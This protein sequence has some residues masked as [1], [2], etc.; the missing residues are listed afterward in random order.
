MFRG[1]CVCASL[2]LAAERQACSLHSLLGACRMDDQPCASTGPRA[3]ACYSLL[4]Q[5]CQHTA[6]SC[7]G[8]LLSSAPPKESVET[9]C[10]E[11]WW[12][13]TLLLMERLFPIRL[14]HDL[15]PVILLLRQCRSY[16][17]ADAGMLPP[18][19]LQELA[20]HLGMSEAKLQCRL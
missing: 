5:T 4:L 13:L 18:L 3:S 7:C 8:V 2:C 20:C 14:L 6:Q 16:H 9:A 10:L 12:S 19:P 17:T 1:G 15:L 11:V